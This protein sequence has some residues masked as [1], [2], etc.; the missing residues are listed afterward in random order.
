MKEK[1]VPVLRERDYLAVLARPLRLSE[2]P[3][4]KKCQG[5]YKYSTWEEGKSREDQI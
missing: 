5:R 2:V 4:Q 1:K 3:P